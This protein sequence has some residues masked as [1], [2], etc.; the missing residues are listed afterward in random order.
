[1]K[2]TEEPRQTILDALR[3]RGAMSIDELAAL[4]DLSKTATRAHVL[5]LEKAG[6]IARMEADP[7]GPGRPRAR[8]ALTQRGAGSFPTADA[9]LLEVL[10]AFL[11]R[12]GHSALIRHFFEELWSERR[13]SLLQS[14][15]VNSFADSSLK[16]RL[17]HLEELLE[18]SDYMPSIERRRQG[19]GKLVVLRE[20]NCPLPAAVRA[21]RI[22]C[23]LEAAFLAEVVGGEALE[24]QLAADRAETCTFEFLVGGAS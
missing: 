15:G 13:S 12:E 22:P 10:L 1:M 5:R 11:E 17:L 18:E 24:T 4:L 7:D 23:Q 8:F 9:E 19:K 20:C 3:R 21:T 6:L 14:L 2:A 16:E